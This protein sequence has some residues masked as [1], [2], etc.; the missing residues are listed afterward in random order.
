MTVDPARLLTR[1]TVVAG[2]TAALREAL[3]A[4]QIQKLDA[5]ADR[6]AAELAAAEAELAALAAGPALPAATAAALRE[7]VNTAVDDDQRLRALLAA[8]AQELPRQ[9]AELRGARAGLGGYQATAVPPG[10]G[11]GV[12]RRG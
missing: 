9:L 1:Y 5:L 3:E 6:R 7:A 2:L 11:D 8:R 10:E 4:D 12:D